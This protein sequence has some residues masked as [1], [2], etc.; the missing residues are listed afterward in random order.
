MRKRANELK[1]GDLFVFDTSALSS[2]LTLGKYHF[3]F[4]KYTSVYLDAVYFTAVLEHIVEEDMPHY[5]QKGLGFIETFGISVPTA[6][7]W[8]EFEIL[9]ETESEEHCNKCAMPLEW[10]SLALRCPKCWTVY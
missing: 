2:K 10:A 6:N 7:A 4:L 9:E 3:R 5:E 1:I 8:P